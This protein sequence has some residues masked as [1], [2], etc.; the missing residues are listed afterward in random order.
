MTDNE[1]K[2]KA[3]I[4]WACHGI[5][6]LPMLDTQE[7]LNKIEYIR[8]EFTGRTAAAR[9]HRRDIDQLELNSME[10]ASANLRHVLPDI[11]SEDHAGIIDDILFNRDCSDLDEDNYFLLDR[12]TIT[13]PG[14]SLA[15]AKERPVIFCTFH[16]GSYRLIN[17]AIISHN[18]NYI[19]PVE[20]KIYATQTARYLENLVSCR[21][22]FSSDSQFMVVNAEEPTAAL[23]MARKARSGWSVLTYIDGN[24]GV[25]GAGRRDAKL[26]KVRLLGKPIYARKGIAF[27]SHFL[28]LPI[29]PVTCE[30]TGPMERTLTFHEKIEPVAGSEDREVYCQMATEKL[31]AVLGTYLKRSPSQWLGWM[32]LQKYI[33]LDGLEENEC[34]DELNAGVVQEPDEISGNRLVFNHHRF[35]FIVQDGQRVLLDKSNYKLLS[36][37]ENISDLLESYREPT[38]VISMG[39]SDEHRDTLGELIS[40]QMLSVVNE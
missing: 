17:H 14:S 20:G 4:D 2:P 1:S 40:M 12:T 37:P 9:Q 38:E 24:T 5:E 11:P 33:D 16:V 29:V 32:E 35:G 36:L 27:L 6:N 8:K 10:F 15:A 28:K 34:V 3:N 18:L 30:I 25:Q 26:L 23:S 7:Y 13:D 22:Y 21:A 39:I 19:L 31:Y